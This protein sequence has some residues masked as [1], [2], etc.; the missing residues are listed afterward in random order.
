MYPGDYNL[1]RVTTNWQIHCCNSF[2][3][4]TVTKSVATFFLIY[5]IYLLFQLTLICVSCINFRQKKWIGTWFI[6]IRIHEFDKCNTTVVA[7]LF[8]QLIFILSPICFV[9]H[10][11]FKHSSSTQNLRKENIWRNIS[12]KLWS[13][14]W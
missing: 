10:S 5:N 2:A 7:K 9:T 8:M 12:A 11:Y 3:C 1:W 4:G 6:V 13:I 14:V